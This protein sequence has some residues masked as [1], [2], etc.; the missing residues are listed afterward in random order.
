MSEENKNG[1]VSASIPCQMSNGN[2]ANL[3]VYVGN[4]KEGTNPI[5]NQ[6]NY[7]AERGAKIP[8]GVIK[9]FENLGKL[10]DS[11][12]TPAANLL[13]HFVEENQLN[14]EINNLKNTTNSEI[15]NTANQLEAAGENLEPT[16]GSEYER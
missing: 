9:Q 2:K 5:G 12:N 6:N 3:T 11:S 7:F 16:T 1:I 4:N 13:K 14:G 10:A 15:E 8:E